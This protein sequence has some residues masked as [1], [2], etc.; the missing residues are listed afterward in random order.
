MIREVKVICLLLLVVFNIHGQEFS[1]Q[2]KAWLY[3]VVKKS[4]CLNSNIGPY[5]NYSG[6]KPELPDFYSFNNKLRDK[7]E[8]QLWDSIEYRIVNSPES[9]N[10][11]WDAI[12]SASP[13][14]LAEAAVKL[15]LW[16]LYCEIKS[17]YQENPQFSIN[18]TARY[19]YDEMFKSLPAVVKS[20]TTLKS[21]YQPI[22]LD[23]L[24]PSLNFIKKK[25]AFTKI[26]KVDAATQK[27][28][29]EKWY[30]IV[31]Q[32]V[33]E[34]SEA[35]F[36]ILCKKKIFL[37]GALLA[38]GEGSGSSGLLH[39]Y[40]DVE[41]DNTGTGTGKGIGLFTYKM[42]VKKNELELEST[43]ETEIPLLQD[44]PTLLHLSLWGMDGLKKPLVVIERGNKSY[45]LFGGDEFSPDRNWSKG[46]SYFD[47]LEEYQERKIDQI[48]NDLNKEGGLLSVY[49]RESDNR[50]KIQAQIDKLNLEIDSINKLKE[51][52][53]LAIQQRKNRNEVNLSNLEVKENRLSSLQKKISIEYQKIDKAEKELEQ[54]KDLLGE[55]IQQWVLEDSIFTF[56]DGNMFNMKTQDLIIKDDS[57]N[58][59]KVNV[60]LLAANYSIYSDKKDE[61]QLYIN[62][63]EGVELPLEK[64]NN[65]LIQDTILSKKIY[66]N[67]DEFSCENCFNQQE[68]LKLQKFAKEVI[69]DKKEVNL[70]LTAASIDTL[71]HSNIAQD[72]VNYQSKKELDRYINSRRVEL[73]IVAQNQSYT[74]TIKGFTD[75]GNTKL[76]KVNSELWSVVK[77]YR[78]K[79][80]SLNPALSILRVKSVLSNLESV[81]GIEFSEAKIQVPILQKEI[82]VQQLKEIK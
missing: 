80:Q 64:T 57:S 48:V 68:K 39:E 26:N 81:M 78:N 7:F 53:E 12:S 30:R 14:V 5:F 35:Y 56:D 10:V 59:D 43:T 24:N 32:I 13:G 25:E 17:G 27:R 50:N 38:V 61:V 2:Q 72:K 8:T 45:L 28:F 75:A 54:K 65:I 70:S 44:Q 4:S 77:E 60:R 34:R 33:E 16:E 36:N 49:E 55:N 15:T 1:P 21:K 29:F 67:S 37:S 62:I 52:S 18:T 20:G 73:T 19:I 79:E 51:P 6:P 66:F 9:L 3:K 74:I 47:F 41:D 76:S 22:F 11:N 40:E 31:N 69:E 42:S 58:I 71:N 63:T 82:K 46:T 23:L